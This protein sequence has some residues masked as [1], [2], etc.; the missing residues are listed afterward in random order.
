M[1]SNSANL[2]IFLIDDE[3]GV[4]RAL[5][6]MLKTVLKCTVS[7]FP[8]PADAMKAISSAA[9]NKELENCSPCIVSDLRMPEFDG[10]D[11]LTFRN[12]NHPDIPFI[13][14]SG[15]ATD[16]DI[17]KAHSMGAQAVLKKPFT[18]D[19]LLQALEA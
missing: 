12:Q 2:H 7:A 5:E 14:I 3:S 15:H 19:Q 16:E 10:F 18:P 13:L 1:T 11:V 4:L 17:K 9:N 8:N 6:L